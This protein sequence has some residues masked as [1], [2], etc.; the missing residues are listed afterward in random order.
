ML[1]AC[2]VWPTAPTLMDASGQAVCV[3]A[4]ARIQVAVLIRSSGGSFVGRVV[5]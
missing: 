4:A 3:R 5:A 1:R 2:V